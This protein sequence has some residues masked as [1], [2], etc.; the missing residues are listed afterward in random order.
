MIFKVKGQGV[1][2]L[3]H[4]ILVNTRINILQWIL[5]KLG[6]Y[7]DLKRI[8]NRIYFQGQRSRSQGLIFRR[9]DTPRFALPLFSCRQAYKF[10]PFPYYRP[11]VRPSHIW[12]P[13]DNLRFPK[14]AHFTFIHKVWDY[15]G[16]PSFISDL[17]TFS[18]LE[19][20][21]F[22]LDGNGGIHV[23]NIIPNLFCRN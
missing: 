3:Q 11:S 19:L 5:T 16:I 20:C 18:F 22:T 9:G 21:P 2:F 12:F 8:W 14:A 10:Y 15:K 7:L 6:T 23:H 13:H 4:N 17:T 1:K